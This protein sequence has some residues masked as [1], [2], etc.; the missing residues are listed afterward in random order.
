[1]DAKTYLAVGELMQAAAHQHGITGPI[2]FTVCRAEAA[3]GSNEAFPAPRVHP[4]Y[5][6]A[7]QPWP[8]VPST[9]NTTTGTGDTSPRSSRPGGNTETSTARSTQNTAPKN[10]A[11]ALDTYI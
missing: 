4:I 2:E 5:A 6:G 10:P 3:R 7:K 9:Q 1:M 11:P 8:P